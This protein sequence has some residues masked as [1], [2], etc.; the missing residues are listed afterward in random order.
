MT[1]ARFVLSLPQGLNL[2]QSKVSPPSDKSGTEMPVKSFLLL[3][4]YNAIRTVQSVH[5]SLAAL[6]KVIRG[7]QLLTNEVQHLASALMTQ[8]VRSEYQWS[9]YDISLCLLVWL[10]NA[11][12]MLCRENLKITDFS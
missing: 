2:I 7:T 3:E 8:E 10:Q 12:S 11:V 9:L 4:R 5:A 1:A 6:S